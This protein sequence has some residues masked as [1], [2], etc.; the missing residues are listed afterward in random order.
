[1]SERETFKAYF[2]E[3]FDVVASKDALAWTLDVYL[4]CMRKS[5]EYGDG[6]CLRAIAMML[7]I[8]IVLKELVS[9]TIVEYIMGEINF[10]SLM[11]HLLLSDSHYTCLT[12]NR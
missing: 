7:K 9:N 6:I 5:G 11:F 8:N 4:N 3:S 10:P 2:N 1:M 12:L